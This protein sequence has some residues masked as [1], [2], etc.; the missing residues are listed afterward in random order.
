LEA[1]AQF[2]PLPATLTAATPRSG[3]YFYFRHVPGSRNGKVCADG[4][5][6]WFSTGKL[7]VVPPAPGRRWLNRAE[8]ADA[9]EWLKEIVTT[10][11]T[12]P[13]VVGD[14]SG[15]LLSKAD[16]A[17]EGKSEAGSGFVPKD[18]YTLI[19]RGTRKASFKTQRRVQGLWANLARKGDHRN[20]ELN[21]A[22]WRY[23]EFIRVGDLDPE[24]AA[25]LLRLA[26][27]ANGY[28]DK[29]GEDVIEER[30]DRMLGE[31]TS[32]TV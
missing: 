7:V 9:P 16:S 11:H 27:Q 25:K 21:Y 17:Y 12:P 5:I 4:S 3:R 1:L 24:I 2:P 8:I 31:A 20:N 26:C 19:I 18:I 29:D 14:P 15:S 10:R 32:S 13:M 30:I 6:E 22:A 23:G 28:L